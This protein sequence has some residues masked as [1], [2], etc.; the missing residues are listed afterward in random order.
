[1][2]LTELISKVRDTALFGDDDSPIRMRHVPGDRSGP[3]DLSR[4]T[5]VLGPNGS[6]K[7]L[8]RR[9]VQQVCRQNNVECIHLSMHGRVGG[10]DLGVVRMM[11]YGDEHEDNTG[12]NS[13]QTVLTSITT[14][15]GRDKPHVLFYDEPDIGL[16]DGAAMGVGIAIR[17]YVATAG[18][19]LV[20]AFVATHRRALVHHL[21]TYPDSPDAL[22]LGESPESVRAWLA[23]SEE[24]IP[25]DAVVEQSFKMW[26]AVHEYIKK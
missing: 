20:A 10:M 12:R 24:P 18:P 2:N 26:K 14:S 23:S 19:N 13:A 5:I 21:A 22:L 11:I 3:F 4:L 1:M 8:L 9:V 16:S 17:E 15:K 25:L 6:G 7:S